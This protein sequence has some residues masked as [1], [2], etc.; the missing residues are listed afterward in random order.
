MGAK[1]FMVIGI[2]CADRR[3]DDSVYLR[4]ARRLRSHNPETS[5]CNGVTARIRRGLRG[6]C[7]GCRVDAPRNSAV[8]HRI[9]KHNWHTF[10]RSGNSIGAGV[11]SVG[12]ATGRLR[13]ARNSRRI[14][15]YGWVWRRWYD[16]NMVDGWQDGYIDLSG[17]AAD[18]GSNLTF[19]ACRSRSAYHRSSK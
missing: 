15:R 3:T 11:G 7:A 8:L 2:R 12:C 18:R 1:K 10:E 19:A 9:R 17:N 16:G 6:Y 13:N 14:C 5:V 4:L